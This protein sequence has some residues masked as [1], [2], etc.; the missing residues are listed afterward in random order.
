MKMWLVL[1]TSFGVLLRILLRTTDGIY[2]LNWD[3]V[4]PPLSAPAYFN[5][6]KLKLMFFSSRVLCIFF[7]LHISR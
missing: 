7:F 3:V 6:V 4:M 1:M 2:F 5:S